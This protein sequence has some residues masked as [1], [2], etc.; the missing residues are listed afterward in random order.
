MKTPSVISSH[1]SSSKVSGSPRS[2]ITGGLVACLLLASAITGVAK[3]SPSVYLTFS[4]GGGVAPVTV[5]WSAPITYTLDFTSPN[6]GVNP[7]FVFQAV[8]NSLTAFPVQGSVAGVAPTYTS[9]GVGSG[10]GT[11]TI[12]TFYS[13]GSNFNAV[14]SG[15]VVLWSS[16]DTAPTILT[17]GDVITLSA[18]SLVYGPPSNGAYSGTMPA[19]GY[20]STIVV[21]AAYM[22]VGSGAS[23]IPEPSTYACF[24]GLAALVLAASRRRKIAA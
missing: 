12:N 2:R 14:S 19:N 8:S 7:Y 18:G 16:N 1:H 22:N 5:S 9:T 21:D 3:A 20:Y 23:S 6:S 13:Y 15:D 11:Q 4:G 24:A 17:S 10:D